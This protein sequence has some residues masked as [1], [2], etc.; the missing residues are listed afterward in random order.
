M[1]YKIHRIICQI[2][3]DNILFNLMTRRFDEFFECR[4]VQRSAHKAELSPVSATSAEFFEAFS[5]TLDLEA[6]SQILL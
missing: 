6:F 2:D 5:V 4:K 3:E 1:L